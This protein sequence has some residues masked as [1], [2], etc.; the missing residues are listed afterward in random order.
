MSLFSRVS[1]R[2]RL[3]GGFG[4][5]LS[6]LVVVAAIGTAGISHSVLAFRNFATVTNEM[7]RMLNVDRDV[8]AMRRDAALYIEKGDEAVLAAYKDKEAMMARAL[9]EAH[10]NASDAADQAEI[11]KLEDLFSD[12]TAQYTQLI[13][14]RRRRE[15]I[16]HGMM[17]TYASLIRE[18]LAAII[19][20]SMGEE[21]FRSAALAGLAQQEIL[22]ARAASMRFI[23][24]QEPDLVDEAKSHIEAFD[25]AIDSLLADVDDDF[26]RESAEEARK[27]GHQYGEAFGEFVNSTNAVSARLRGPMADA[28][29][30]FT[31]ASERMRK[32]HVA[33]SQQNEEQTQSALTLAQTGSIAAAGVGVLVGMML[34]WLI[35]RSISRPVRAMTGTMTSLAEGNRAIAVPALDHRDEI[36]E[37][38]RA[39][40]VFK[41]NAIEVERLQGQQETLRRQAEEARRHSTFALADAFEAGVKSAVTSVAETASRI[42][43]AARSM[44]TVAAHA[45]QQSS[46]GLSAADQAAANVQS[47]AAASE[48]L[49]SSVGEIS[50][51]VGEAAVISRR[52]SDDAD[53]MSERVVA[54]ADVTRNISAVTSM[55]DDI[56]AKT[57]L[58]ALNATIEAAR[59]G[60]AGKGFAVVA[61]EVKALAQQTAKA[62]GEITRQVA[63]IQTA[64]DEMVEVIVGISSTILR[65]N[66]ISSTIAAAVEQQS[67]ATQEIARN[68]QEAATGT[69]EVNTSISGISKTARETGSAAGEVLDAVVVLGRT[70]ADLRG[71]VERF[72]S[73]V[74]AA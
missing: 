53:R 67:A 54:F 74:R 59:A 72:L 18:H 2:L 3:F 25:T 38:A 42:E 73:Q 37:M 33:L 34:A 9:K 64:S 43:D 69:Q 13:D 49:S 45:S 14:L 21:H 23:A 57:N 19:D 60:E 66:E 40:Q 11:K 17:D 41:D 50:R 6:V 15:D 65:F 5:V 29:N 44:S 52:A 47:V 32:N 62:T 68:A 20:I 71:E 22:T 35:A 61:S 16:L 48:Q 4:L 27:L 63:G 7:T 56:A 1:I 55:I 26:I 36:G 28:A 70:S 12:Y 31:A 10:M 46:A 24:Y 30:A 39:V 51:Q 8:M 58:L